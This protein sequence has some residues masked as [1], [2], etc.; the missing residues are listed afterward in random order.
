MKEVPRT[1]SD[2]QTFFTEGDNMKNR[3]V[4]SNNSNE[5]KNYKKKKQ[6]DID[7][8]AFNA[9]VSKSFTDLWLQ[10]LGYPNG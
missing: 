1:L 4:R 7:F 3:Q 9:N 6:D 5:N 8:T 2:I 10:I